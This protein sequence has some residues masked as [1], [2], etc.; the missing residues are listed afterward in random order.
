MSRPVKIVA[1]VAGAIVAL[2]IVAAI[3]VPLAF[4]PNDYKEQIAAQAAATTGRKLDI[5]GDLDLSVFP[6]LGVETG[7]L[8]LENAEG[9]G[10]APFLTLERADVR[11]KLLPLLQRRLEVGRIVVEGLRV[12]LQRDAS[13]R[14]NWDD[15]LEREA[16]PP[17]E[18]GAEPTPELEVAGLE[19]RDATVSWRDAQAQTSYVV[20]G[21]SLETGALRAGEPVDVDLALTV[22]DGVPGYTAEL[23]LA[24]TLQ[25]DTDAGRYGAD[26][27]ELEYALREKEG[28]RSY[29]GTLSGKVAA[30]TAQSVYTLQDVK[31]AGELP[32][33]EPDAPPLRIAGAWTTARYDQAGNVV[34]ADDITLEAAGVKATVT[35]LEGTNLQESPRVTGVLDV[36]PFSLP[37]LLETL[38]IELPDGADPSALGTA[39]LRAQVVAE[40]SVP[41]F[42]LTNLR[43]DALGMRVE[44]DLRS[45]GGKLAGTLRAPEF[46]TAT[47]FAAL[48]N[49][50]PQDVNVRAIDRLALAAS[51]ETDSATGALVIRD[52]KADLLG[53]TVTA[54]VRVTDLGGPTARYAGSVRTGQ[55]PPQ[56]VAA[57]FGPLLPAGVEASELGQLSIG[58]RFDMRAADQ[59][60]RLEELDATAAG[61]HVTG[62]VTMS[63]F[64]D[65]TEYAGDLAVARFNPRALMKRFGLKPPVTAD[66][67]VFKAVSG[68]ARL[69]ATATS[70]RLESLDLRLDQTRLGGSLAITDFENPAYEFDLTIDDVDVDRYLPPASKSEEQQEQVEETGDIIIP[71]DALKTLRVAGK[72]QAKALKIGGI[73]VSQLAATLAARD[74]LARLEP[75]SA[76]L[77]RGAFSG[78]FTADA[79]GQ[80]PAMTVKGQV[81]DMRVGEFLKGMSGEAPALTG[82][83]TFNL[84]L[85]GAG[86]TYGQNLASADGSV[87]FSLRD[88]AVAGLDLAHSLCT[89]YNLVKRLPKPTAKA[90]KNS[91]FKIVSGSAVVTDGVA[92]TKDLKGST[93]FLTATGGGTINLSKETVDIDLTAKMIA[94]IKLAGCAQ[95]KD[96]VGQ[97][98]PIDISGSITAPS[99]KPDYGEIAKDVIK[100]KIGD[101]I[102]DRLLDVLGDKDKKQPEKKP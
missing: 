32:A 44:G 85:A 36:A 64:P 42:A 66:P 22:A 29:E 26:D 55:V 92:T 1:I 94:A 28:E 102:K 65:A 45:A 101:E 39:S 87:S 52:A 33:M 10:D 100:D 96:L 60:L 30:D 40:P 98:L 57:V 50:L 8:S 82:T 12:D 83:G 81:A 68:A 27:L 24:G 84:E 97:T 79:R 76:R 69:T 19:L 74:G 17:P 9:F 18:Q 88:G 48:G 63:K 58:T 38:A 25:A 72:V 89:G 51:F 75:I 34:A 77:Y 93:E 86:A 5:E 47:L 71:V 62:A 67:K 23:R 90:G 11:V 54:D 7:R 37:Q 4:D 35:Q 95:T 70:A 53:T 3:V 80:T 61:L 49:A 43:A 73:S 14:T 13:G 21:I 16:T 78:A 41:S 59:V 99:V 6:W 56:Q 91:P 31:L 15:L 20:S 2:V 46:R